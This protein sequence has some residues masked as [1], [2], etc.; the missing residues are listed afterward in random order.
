MDELLSTDGHRYDRVREVA[1]VDLNVL[2][3]AH[4]I[5][6]CE[7]MPVTVA[8]ISEN[9]HIYIALWLHDEELGLK[10]LSHIPAPFNASNYSP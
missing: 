10:S 6:V 2:Y 8:T 9:R 3:N 5:Q 4:Y 7:A 1:I